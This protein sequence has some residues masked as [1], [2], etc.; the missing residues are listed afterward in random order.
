MNFNEK[1]KVY[2]EMIKNSPHLM[3]KFSPKKI[4]KKVESPLEKLKNLRKEKIAGN[5]NIRPTESSNEASRKLLPRVKPDDVKLVAYELKLRFILKKI[6]IN[7]IEKVGSLCSIL[8]R[9]IFSFFLMK[10]SKQKGVH[11]FQK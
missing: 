5:L 10:K 4:E 2:Q 3:D 1:E 8:L 9:T 11:Q 6:D 7:S